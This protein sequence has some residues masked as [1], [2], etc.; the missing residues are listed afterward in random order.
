MHSLKTRKGL[1]EGFPKL[2]V[3]FWGYWGPLF[4]EATILYNALDIVVAG[5]L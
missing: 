3:P 1:Y 4:L 5:L 2:G